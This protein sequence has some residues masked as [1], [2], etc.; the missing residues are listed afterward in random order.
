MLVLL[1]IVLVLLLVEVVQV[2]L[3]VG[4]ELPLL[5][6]MLLLARTSGFRC[7]FNVLETLFVSGDFFQLVYAAVSER[8]LVYGYLQCFNTVGFKKRA[9]VASFTRV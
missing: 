3:L 4:L 6:V 5:L 8:S 2:V 7:V 1:L 9:A